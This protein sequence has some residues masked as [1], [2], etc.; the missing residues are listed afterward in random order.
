[1]DNFTPFNPSSAAGRSHSLSSHMMPQANVGHNIFVWTIR[2][3]HQIKST[4]IPMN[5]LT[6]KKGS[7]RNGIAS[8]IGSGTY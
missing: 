6:T 1:M 8:A 4:I 3:F 7:L 2:Y 5:K